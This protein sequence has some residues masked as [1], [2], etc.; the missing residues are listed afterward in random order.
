MRTQDPDVSG[1][2]NS[3]VFDSRCGVF[4]GQASARWRKCL[5]EFTLGES[6]QLKVCSDY[7]QVLQLEVK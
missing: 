6:E 5:R 3:D 7:R 2:R 1:P 4:V